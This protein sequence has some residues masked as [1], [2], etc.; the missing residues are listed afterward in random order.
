MH[1]TAG[2]DPPVQYEPDGQWTLFVAHDAGQYVPPTPVHATAGAD[3]PVQYE[4][5][6]QATPTSFTLSGPQYNPGVGAVHGTA[7]AKEP[8][9]NEPDGHVAHAVAP[10]NGA[11]YAMPGAQP[12]VCWSPM[13]Q[14]PIAGWLEQ[15]SVAPVKKLCDTFLQKQPER[16]SAGQCTDNNSQVLQRAVQGPQTHRYR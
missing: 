6:G 2:A 4:P 10:Q 9:Q 15:K 16:A 1:A 5:D 14:C 3:L 13:E 12:Q 7:S 11:T 8:P